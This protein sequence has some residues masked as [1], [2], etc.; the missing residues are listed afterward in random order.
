LLAALL[1]LGVAACGNSA[2]G[3]DGT[4]STE[5]SGQQVVGA[6]STTQEVAQEHWTSEYFLGP[7]DL[8]V[9]Y[10]P[11]GSYEGVERFL[12]GDVAFAGSDVPLAAG[13]LEE[14]EDRCAPGQAIEIPAYISPLE[15]AYNLRNSGLELSPATVAK[16]FNGE[17]SRWDDLRI[18]RQNPTI[19]S[20]GLPEK[21]RISPVYRAGDSGATQALTE[22]LAASAPEAWPDGAG[23]EW[24]LS[25][26]EAVEGTKGTV[27]AVFAREGAVGYVDSSQRSTLGVVSV[28]V[29][30]KWVTPSPLSAATAFAEATEDKAL[31][32]NRYMLP[33]KI[34]RKGGKGGYPITVVSY[35]IACTRYDSTEEAAAI[36]G[37]LDYVISREG[38]ELVVEEAGAAPL[39]PS[40]L[41]RV[42]AAVE[43]IE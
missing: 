32:A 7:K 23:S 28:K 26:G 12:A 39:P 40:L 22:Y 36:R 4:G 10:E 42:R 20:I 34:D 33:F 13:E 41:P 30:S 27:E 5:G 17:I 19:S 25:R 24:P 37:Y 29:G 21:L 1:A 9:S 2:S 14:A 11:V 35:L 16:I 31:S 15:I 6:G 38:Q 43:A 8:T 3:G 18:R